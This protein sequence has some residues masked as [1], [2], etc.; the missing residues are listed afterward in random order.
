MWRRL[1]RSGLRKRNT[2]LGVYVAADLSVYLFAGLEATVGDP[3]KSST[4]P[5][6]AE[7]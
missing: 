4:P 5:C 3:R 7:V 1:P 6:M 2:P